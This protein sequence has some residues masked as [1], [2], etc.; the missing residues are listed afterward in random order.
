MRVE[1]FLVV[2]S[3]LLC[4]VERLKETRVLYYVVVEPLVPDLGEK[5][6]AKVIQVERVVGG[7]STCTNGG[8]T[9]PGRAVRQG[10]SIPP[11]GFL[12]KT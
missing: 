8:S 5:C 6:V 9:A 7:A 12:A 3:C 1:D 11:G 4:Q 2:L 10:N